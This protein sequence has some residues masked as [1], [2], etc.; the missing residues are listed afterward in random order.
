MQILVL[1]HGKKHKTQDGTLCFTANINISK[2]T[3]LDKDKSIHPH[4]LQDWRKPI[5][6]STKYDIITTMCCDSDAFYNKQTNRII[7]QSF[8]NVAKALKKNGLFIFPKYYWM[9]SRIL[10]DIQQHLH[11]IKTV[12]NKHDTFYYFTS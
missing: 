4:I 11:L 1:C 3:L 9:T 7:A 12:Q 6:F 8:A 5:S 10:K 2:A